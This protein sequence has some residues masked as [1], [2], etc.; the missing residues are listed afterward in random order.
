MISED[1]TNHLFYETSPYL[2]QHAHN[3]VDWFPWGEEARTSRCSSPSAILPVIGATYTKVTYEQ[4]HQGIGKPPQFLRFSI[5]RD[6]SGRAHAPCDL[7][8]RPLKVAC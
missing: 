1:Y 8:R 7:N 4:P 2:L 5:K 6:K 3:P